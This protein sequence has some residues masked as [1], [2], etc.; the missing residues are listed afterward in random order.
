M[1]TSHSWTRL[2][3]VWFPC[4]DIRNDDQI[5]LTQRDSSKRYSRQ[6]EW[7]RLITKILLQPMTSQDLTS[8][9]RDLNWNYS[10][11]IGQLLYLSSNTRPDIQFAVHGVLVSL[12]HPRVSWSSSPSV[13]T[14]PELPMMASSSHPTCIGRDSTLLCVDADYAGHSHEMIKTP[15]ASESR[16]GFV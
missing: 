15:S 12:T 14:W 5:E 8:M 13:V 3:H 9:V 2:R 7:P 4:I 10:S 1:D 6:L 11:A 16:T